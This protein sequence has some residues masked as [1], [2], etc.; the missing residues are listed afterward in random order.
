MNWGSLCLYSI[1]LKGTDMDLLNTLIVLL[2][3]ICL[4]ALLL[5]LLR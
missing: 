3:V 1:T 2:V 5:K 4:V